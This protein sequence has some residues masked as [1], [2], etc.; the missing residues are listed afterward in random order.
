MPTMEQT[1]TTNQ[2]TI[3]KKEK[4]EAVQHTQSPSVLIQTNYKYNSFCFADTMKFLLSAALILAS[5]NAFTRTHIT[6][7]KA[8]SSSSSFTGSS[9]SLLQATNA[10]SADF[11]GGAELNPSAMGGSNLEQI[12]FKIYPD[13]RVEETVKGVRGY[14]CHKVTEK[15]NESLGKVID[16]SPTE[17]LYENEVVITNEQTLSN[18]VNTDDSWEGQSSW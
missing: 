5:A 1:K 10:G 14:N 17:D 12:E 7:T 6:L 9:P 3:Q 15:I 18:Q 13:G 2:H 4:R 11:G 8:S 16:S